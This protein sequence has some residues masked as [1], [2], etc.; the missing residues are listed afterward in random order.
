MGASVGTLDSLPRRFLKAVNLRPEE[1]ERTVLMFLFYAATSIGAVWL[2]GASSSLFVGIYDVENLT[3]I[4]MA[5][6]IAVTGL[7]V[8]YSW[9][10][11]HFPLR[12]VMLGVSILL[13]VPLPGLWFALGQP[14]TLAYGVALFGMRLWVEAVYVLSNINNDI[15]ANQLFNIR[16][17]KRTFPLISTGIIVAEIASGFSL[18]FLIGAIGIGNVTL[19]AGF[20]LLIGS[21]LLFYLSTRYRQ[22]FPNA[23]YSDAEDGELSTSQMQGNLRQYVV[24]LFGFFIAAQIL[25]FLIDFQYYAQLKE[26]LVT[27]EAIASFVGIFGGVMGVFKL[28][29]QLFGSSRLIER[30]GLFLAVLVPP[31][32]IV[33]AGSLA[34]AAP[35]GLLIG[36]AILKFFDE[37]FRFTIFA[38]TAPTLFQAV[39]DQFRSQI[40]SLVRGIADPV[41]VG[42]AGVLIWLLLQALRALGLSADTSAQIFAG[43]IVAGGVVWI[44]D[45]LLLRRG[46]IELLIQSV[47]R[48]QLS[49]TEVDIREVRRAVT[50]SLLRA[51][52]PLDQSV[53]IELLTQVAPQTVGESLAPLLSQMSADLQRQSLEAML[54]A[55]DAKYVPY[56]DEVL[57]SPRST[58]EVQANCLRYILLSDGERQDVGTLRQFLGH[59]QHPVIRSTAV[60]LIMRLGSPAQIAE[61][62][63][64]L[65]QMLTSPQKSDRILGCRALAEA[66]Y[67]QSLRFY[68]PQLLQD[69]SIEVRSALLQAIAATRTAEYF[70]SLIRG[71]HYKATSHAAYDALVKLGDD[72]VD[73]LVSLALNAKSPE[74]VRLN[75]WK[76]LGEIGTPGAIAML[77]SHLPKS[78]GK[79]RRTILRTLIRIPK[80]VGI[81]SVLETIGRTGVEQ[82]VTQE[83][84]VVGE[85]W[86]AILDL[87]EDQIPSTEVSLLC[88]AL[89]TEVADSFD[90]LFL[91]MK[92][93]YPASA[94]QAAA[95][96]IV[97]ASRSNVARGI[98]I[99]DNTVDLSTKQTLLTIMDQRPIA[100][101]MRA[102]SL[103]HP[104]VPTSGPKRL[105]NLVELHYCF[106]DWLLSCCFHVARVQWWSLPPELTLQCLEHPAVYVREAVLSYLQVASPRS[107]E[108]LL[109][110]LVNDPH[111]LLAAQAR[112]IAQFFAANGRKPHA[113]QH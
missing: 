2:E 84:V 74:A 64:T 61:A 47:E 94:I 105:R 58:P 93:L 46:Y 52:Q 31:L 13:A 25:F 7:G 35:F 104:Y 110:K 86:A 109:P 112:A 80:E 73:L 23:V 42:V 27:E 99:L 75:A 18:P 65:R 21:A 28:G 16:E 67:M 98:E 88:S 111:P 20:M 97:S 100:D 72:A 40:Q 55:P 81:E 37:L 54:I 45:I 70:P 1:A 68:V 103:V 11:K 59:E 96:N 12:R 57:R 51:E 50:E 22:A 69:P 32:G 9:L 102:L 82:M 85:A 5:T 24:L 106:G 17:I 14:N 44:L 53:F 19:A 60:A 3:W 83:L 87:P 79:Q 8:S 41:S 63:N 78:W 66:T 33:L 43:L 89:H 56:V 34:I 92:L 95:F 26:R 49:L 4:Y 76:I 6:A 30:V 77:A 90:R 15:A 101:K 113:H 108:R 29:L 48:G 10:Q 71:L 62:T 38:T 107:L 91:C 39:P 36:Y